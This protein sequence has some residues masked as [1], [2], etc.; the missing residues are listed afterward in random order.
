M[1]GILLGATPRFASPRS[2]AIVGDSIVLSDTNAILLFR[3]GAQ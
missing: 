2:L 3:H 1:A